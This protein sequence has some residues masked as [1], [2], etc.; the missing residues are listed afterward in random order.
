MIFQFQKTTIG[1][2]SVIS[3]IILIIATLDLSNN[4]YTGL[5]IF[6]IISAIVVGVSEF[7][8]LFT[9]LT[10]FLIAYLFNPI[11]PIY[12]FKKSLWIPIDI[13]CAMLFF[14]NGISIG[15]NT[16]QQNR[17]IKKN[18]KDYGRDKLY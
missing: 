8:S 11:Y 10:F 12:L 15:N 14:L 7:K 16:K 5:R 18:V 13:I 17:I 9:L 6:I 1:Y 4:F 3:S 2:L